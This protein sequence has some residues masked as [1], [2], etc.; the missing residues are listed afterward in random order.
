M[1][2]IAEAANTAVQRLIYAREAG[3]EGWNGSFAEIVFNVSRAEP[4]VT[5]PREI[6]RLEVIN[7]CNHPVPVSNQFA[8]Y[9]RFGNGRM[10]KQHRHCAGAEIR[11]MYSRNNAVTFI[12]MTA[13]PQFIS[14]YLTDAQDV[15]KRILIQG[16]D[17][18]SQVI[19]SQDNSNQVTGVFLTLNSPSVMTAM[20]LTALQGI[21]KDITVGP[22]RIYQHDPTTGDEILLLTM[23]PGEMTAQY[24]RYYLHS[25]PTNCCQTPGNPSTVQ[26]TA[27]AKLEPIPMVVDTDYALLNNLQAI[28]AECQSVRYDEMDT[29]SAKQMARE[30]HEY[31][32]GLL[33]GELAHAQGKDSLA[34][35][36]APFGSARLAK[37][38]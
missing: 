34:V 20:T 32:I 33:N 35:G 28:I 14:A 22:V 37:R 17:A 21:Q 9:L 19:Y 31:A 6:A 29:T 3:D 4:Y 1:T 11:E 23:Q 10:P 12:E 38:R 8:E 25:L 16:L 13:A 18:D 30:R 2:Q 7:V 27:I 36:F 5:L 15:G 24:R 26:V